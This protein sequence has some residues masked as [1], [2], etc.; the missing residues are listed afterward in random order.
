MQA[1]QSFCLI[2]EFMTT[3]ARRYVHIY[4]PFSFSYFIRDFW[5]RVRD[6]FARQ[7]KDHLRRAGSLKNVVA[8]IKAFFE[9]AAVSHFYGSRRGS[10]LLA[11]CET[12]PRRGDF[13]HSRLQLC[14]LRRPQLCGSAQTINTTCQ[15]VRRF[16]RTHTEQLF[17]ERRAVMPAWGFWSNLHVM[18]IADF[19]WTHCHL[20][21]I[22][23][24]I[25]FRFIN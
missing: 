19:K 23:Y 6:Y 14:K 5:R 8:A 7:T 1:H 11:P 20:I 3:I 25:F 22:S 10:W 18:L 12:M 4:F 16:A 15:F 21:W 13:S 9:A 17:I 2:V 24:Y